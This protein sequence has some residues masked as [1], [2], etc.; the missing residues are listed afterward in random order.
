MSDNFKF[1][2]AGGGSLKNALTIAFSQTKK[3]VGWRVDIREGKSNRLLF[4]KYSSD[5]MTPFPAPLDQDQTETVIQSW[6]DDYSFGQAPDI[7]G[8]CGKGF[9]VYNEDWNQVNH[10]Y[11]A[12]FAVEPYWEMYGK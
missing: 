2:I 3:A 7:D 9:H 5:K 10:E 6:L 8:N 12:F 4:Y 11:Q 1:D